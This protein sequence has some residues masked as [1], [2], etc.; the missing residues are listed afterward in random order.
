LTESNLTLE[1]IMNDLQLEVI[2]EP[3]RKVRQAPALVFVHGAFAGAWCWLPMMKTCAAAGFECWA[4]SVRGHGESPDPQ[5]LNSYCIDDYVD[6]L[7]RVVAGLPQPPLLIGHS[8]GG[9]IAQ[10]YLARGPVA[11]L[12][13][14]ASVPP[15]GLAG[16]ACY[17]AALNPHLLWLLNCFQFGAA[18]DFNLADVRDLLFSADMPD[19]A[20]QRFVAQA[21]PESLQALWDMSLPQPWRLWSLPKVPALVVGAG[22]DRIIPAADIEV[23]AHALGV[24]PVFVEGV[25]HALMLDAGWEKVAQTLLAWLERSPWQR[26]AH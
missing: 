19:E 8:M 5:R 25:G 2:H 9:F 26:P 22:S 4:V 16:S 3:A 12:A 1:G 15:Y 11:G 20:L 10:R 13:L 24:D 6:D 23:T 7:A 21:Q 18:R 14:L 17:L